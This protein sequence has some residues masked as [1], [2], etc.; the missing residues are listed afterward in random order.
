[1]AAGD[2][3]AQAP[4]DLAGWERPVGRAIHPFTCYS[5]E[6]A[7][8]GGRPEEAAFSPTPAVMEAMVRADADPASRASIETA[9]GKAS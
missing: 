1:M 8:A 6:P 7:E 5:P 4:Q 2:R 9:I 3:E